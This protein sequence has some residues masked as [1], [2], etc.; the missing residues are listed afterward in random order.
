MKLSR[1]IN[2]VVGILSI[3]ILIFLYNKTKMVNI[4]QYNRVIDTL[5]ELKQLDATWTEEVL[6]SRLSLNNNYDN[7]TAITTDIELARDR[8]LAFDIAQVETQKNAYLALLK[9]RTELIEQFKSVNAILS[10][11]I[12]YFPIAV[13]E[14]K[15]F[16]SNLPANQ[17]L[18]A[19][20]KYSL[21]S[22][23][24]TRA[25]IPALIA[26]LQAGDTDE[27]LTEQI[28]IISSHARAIVKYK[29]EIDALLEKI[30]ALNAATLLDALTD[31]YVDLKN[32]RLLEREPYR[33]TLIIFS[34]IL[35]L[36]ITYI[37]SRLGLSYK[38][39]DVANRQLQTANETLEKRVEERTKELSDAL[40]RLKESQSQLIQSEKMAS[41]GQM[42]AGV[43]HE[44]NTPLGYIK[45]NVQLTQSIVV[46]FRDFLQ[47]QG[48]LMGLF[49]SETV[50]EEKLHTQLEIV[51]ELTKNFQED[52]TIK[53]AEE[54]LNDSLHGLAQ[55]SE[56]VINL[57]NFSRLDL[58]KV[59]NVDLHEQCL[60]SSL[61]IANNLLKDKITVNKEYGD[62]PKIKCS[63]SQIN[64]VF[65]NLLTNAAHAIET[66]GTIL[67]KTRAENGRVSVEIQ[68]DGKGIAE[69]LL[70][71]IFDP[72]FT[73]KKIGEGSGM[74]LS[75]AYKI[76][77]QHNGDID[78][79]SEV[80]K[81][82]T[83]VVSLPIQ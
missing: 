76:I 75:I 48:K 66:Q 74:G 22:D 33:R 37:G 1:L 11:S 42:V 55:I 43:T 57:K 3:A 69:E 25:Q 27:D 59:S 32:A 47:E 79:T 15:E 30:A 53:D 71:K 19:V 17:L 82:T 51:T 83:F 18:T 68:D 40:R 46:Q 52:E 64:Q 70:P 39:L 20:L 26:A 63:P 9:E 23:A 44:I 8:W 58:A 49:S 4:E 36:W 65:L 73:T 61:L 34:G 72:F 38:A 14:L 5:R 80:G 67:I 81:G 6:R 77:Q 78:V 7:L 21:V 50:D 12:R 31:T 29:Q 24:Q 62:I 13:A 28:D 35:L 41:L 45:S 54:L 60:D 10:N 56:L 2:I 16:S